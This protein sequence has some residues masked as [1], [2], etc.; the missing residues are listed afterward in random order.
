M[1]LLACLAFVAVLA[2]PSAGRADGD[3]ASDYLL[4]RDTFL[5]YPPPTESA[6]SALSAAIA[7]VHQSNGR[8]KVAV[9]ASPND[10]GSVPSLFDKPGGYAKFLGLEIRFAYDAALLVVMPAGFGLYEN[11]TPTPQGDDVLARLGISDR[12]ADGLTRAAATAVTALDRVGALVYTDTKKPLA[13]P[14]VE[15]GRAGRPLKLL[16]RASDDSGRAAVA[17]SVL[18][19]GTAI[20]RFKVPLRAAVAGTLYAVQWQVPRGE[21][22]HALAFCARATDPSG[23]SSALTCAKLTIR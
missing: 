10:L 2:L 14:L 19:G 13:V 20:A 12:S 18:D 7:S 4:V 21:A 22:R 3:P 23:N 6:R 5:P 16:Y 8:V 15:S 9:I 11:G 17:L 1:R